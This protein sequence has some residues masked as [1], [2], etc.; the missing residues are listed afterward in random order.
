MMYPDNV[1]LASEHVEIVKDCSVRSGP[2]DSCSAVMDVHVGD[3]F[4][5]AGLVNKENGWLEVELSQDIFGWVSP[6]DGRLTA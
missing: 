1:I 3:I 2:F 4:P 5:F 6:Q